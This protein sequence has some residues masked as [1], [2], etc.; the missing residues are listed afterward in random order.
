MREG[1]EIKDGCFKF[2]VETFRRKIDQKN[3][4]FLI[5]AEMQY[6]VSNI[7]KSHQRPFTIIIYCFQ[8]RR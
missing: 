5:G 2:D 4:T 8:T 1:G 3:T 6:V 7:G